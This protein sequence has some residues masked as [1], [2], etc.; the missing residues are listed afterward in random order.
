MKTIITAPIEEF[1]T[2]KKLRLMYSERQLKAIYELLQSKEFGPVMRKHLRSQGL[3][4][5]GTENIPLDGAFKGFTETVFIV[6]II[7]E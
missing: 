7:G 6:D 2:N 3:I 1:I 5:T 4:T